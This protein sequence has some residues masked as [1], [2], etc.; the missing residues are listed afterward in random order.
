MK[1]N[2]EKHEDQVILKNVSQYPNN[3]TYSFEQS[4]KELGR[5]PLSC[6]GRY[7]TKLRFN[8]NAIVLVGKSGQMTL[9]NQKNARRNFEEKFTD[10]D[11][12]DIIKEMVQKLPKK[13]KRELIKIVFC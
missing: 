8:E 4:A 12:F 9:N 6:S 1:V 2:F 7:Y 5:T 11:R 13:M 3:L 10:E